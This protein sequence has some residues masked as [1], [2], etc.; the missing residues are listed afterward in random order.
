MSPLW[1][2]QIKKPLG[3]TAKWRRNGN[4]LSFRGV[5]KLATE[6]PLSDQFT[7]SNGAAT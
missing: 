5:S 3:I 7:A 4:C 2:D 1:V 6:N